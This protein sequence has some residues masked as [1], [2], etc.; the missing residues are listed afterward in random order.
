[1]AWIGLL[2][3]TICFIELAGRLDLAGR[4]ARV[5]AIGAKAIST[6][7]SRGIS[8]RWKERALLAYARRMFIDSWASFALLLLCVAPVVALTAVAAL[9]DPHAWQSVGSLAGL[10][11]ATVTAIVY[12]S[13]RKRFARR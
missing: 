12:I 6:I 13:G 10:G 2:V 1:M 3:G 11:V 4:L 5:P 9:A 7:G 8:D